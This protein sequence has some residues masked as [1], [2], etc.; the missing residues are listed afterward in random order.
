[1]SAFVFL[2]IGVIFHDK[3]KI[4]AI[5]C[6]I[7]TGLILVFSIVF[8][9]LKT[10]QQKPLITKA[11]YDEFMVLVNKNE[12]NPKYISETNKEVIFKDALLEYDNQEYAYEDLVAGICVKYNP[13]MLH[14]DVS[15]VLII[16]SDE[17]E[18]I[19]PFSGQLLEKV[20]DAGIEIF[21][22]EDYEY[23]LGNFDV[24]IKKI[25]RQLIPQQRFFPL[26]FSK[27]KEEK[28]V[29]RSINIKL[30]LFTVGFIALAILVLILLSWLGESREG[31]KITN[32]FGFNLGIKI[33]FSGVIVLL[34]FFKASKIETYGKILF[35]AYLLSYWMG[36][37]VLSPRSNML[38]TVLFFIA[39][40]L[41]G[42]IELDFKDM[43]DSPF[44]RFLGFSFFLFLM[45][46]ARTLYLKFVNEG[47]VA[48][49]AAIITAVIT[50]ISIVF[51]IKYYKLNIK[52]ED[53]VKKKVITGSIS[54]PFSTLIISFILLF[55]FI[56]A[57]N[58]AFDTSQRQFIDC[59]VDG[60]EMNDKYSDSVIV[61]I[62]NKEVKIPISRE[63]YYNLKLHEPIYISYYSGALGLDYYIYE[64]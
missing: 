11:F 32:S 52:K 7:A 18:M 51:A 55:F 36:S 24:C 3:A 5:L 41:V 16:T 56:Q 33:L 9:I 14:T 34:A 10:K 62:N 60:L 49:I 53:K 26:F 42:I 25:L 15:F 20:K 1:M 46:G 61:I 12:D 30:K 28:K 59:T 2:I 37:L 19:L 57:V 27:N 29:E 4:T 8:M 48:S 54:I 43:K 64:K 58:Y 23:M 39:F 22:Y 50:I 63:D 13:K 17:E 40:V 35:I 21:N 45:I 38:F 44:N 47:K 6:Y 31:L